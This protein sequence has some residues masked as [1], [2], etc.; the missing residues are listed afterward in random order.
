MNFPTEFP[1]NFS[2]DKIVVTVR[3][4]GTETKYMSAIAFTV[5]DF[6]MWDYNSNSITRDDYLQVLEVGARAMAEK[7][8][9]LIDDESGEY[10]IS[11]TFQGQSS[12]GVLIN[13]GE[14]SE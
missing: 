14:E 5:S 6:G 9:D 12:S 4:V 8:K 1:T 2:A 13:T 11:L 7:M 3:P 10:E